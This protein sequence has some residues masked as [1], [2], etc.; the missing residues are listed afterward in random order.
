MSID[1]NAERTYYGST[2]NFKKQ[3]LQKQADF[4]GSMDGASKFSDDIAGI[5]ITVVNVIEEY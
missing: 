2:G 3:K 5:I 1:G 4:Y